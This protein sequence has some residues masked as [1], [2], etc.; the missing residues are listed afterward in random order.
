MNVGPDPWNCPCAL[1]YNACIILHNQHCTKN[2]S[3]TFG[4][5]TNPRADDPSVAPRIRIRIS[6]SL[7]NR[8]DRWDKEACD[9][10]NFCFT[11]DLVQLELFAG[12]H[13]SNLTYNQIE[14]HARVYIDNDMSMQLYTFH[15]FAFPRVP[16]IL[17]PWFI[18][19]VRAEV[20]AKNLVSCIYLWA[21]M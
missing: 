6:R 1:H 20:K 18:Q 13:D 17:R 19:K 21:S 14:P 3:R 10:Q 2:C 4:K 7:E 16:Q 8:A 15:H 5:L 9:S 12:L 11:S